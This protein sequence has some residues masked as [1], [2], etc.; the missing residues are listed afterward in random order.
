MANQGVKRS[1]P[2]M[3]ST[4][5]MFAFF[6]AAMI[7]APLASIL[8]MAFDANEPVWAQLAT[9]LPRILQ[10]TLLL[11]VAV[12]IGT[13][14]VGSA[15]AWLVTFYRF[16]GVGWLKWLLFA[17]LA[18][19]AY[20]AAYALVDFLEYAGPLQTSMRTAFGWS[21]AADYPFFDVR[22][23]GVAT[24]V[25]TLTLYPY[26]YLLT[27]AALREQSGAVFEVARSLGSSGVRAYLNVGLPLARPAIVAG[28]MIAMMET[29]ADFGTVEFF[30]V[31]TLTTGIFSLWLEAGN[32]G[33]AA[34]LAIIALFF[35]AIL[36]SVERFSRRR[37]KFYQSAQS[38]RPLVP[39]RLQGWRALTA[40][41]ICL[42]PVV[43]G[44]ALPVLIMAGHALEVSWADISL[45][46]AV[47][48]TIL[49]GLSAALV[50]TIVATL[51]VYSVR[52]AG[53]SGTRY[54][55]P[56]TSLGYA[57]PGAI[58]GLGVLIPLAAID[59]Q[60]ADMAERVTGS[61]PGLI[62][63]GSAFAIV[64]ACVVRFFAIPQG[65]A[66]AAFGRV[67][68]SLPLASRSLG[69]SA[70]GALRRVYL[71]MMRTSIATAL[72]LVFV[73]TVKELPATLMLRPFNFNTL[74]T[75]TYEKASLEN[76]AEAAPPAFLI[77]LVG[78]AAVAVVARTHR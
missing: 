76:I 11:M 68:P 12:G 8:V 75:R 15:T 57:T 25:L 5:S 54:L 14:I 47:G 33:G 70:G 29:L 17:P 18:I 39:E 27:R 63:T 10:N 58:L 49:V 38:T 53:G 26:T 44:F 37:M 61:D 7:L 50:A 28:S 66:D 56:A 71:P 40:L 67:S 73:D 74:A 35:V 31:Q 24:L 4:A 59:H 22:S 34:Q 65:A 51:L 48:N 30:A 78:L 52:L 43:L 3:P 69:Q 13:A 60:F 64:F 42:L 46:A 45:L 2:V 6:V 72:L 55:L 16:P 19:P 20:V 32:R 77:I 9:T 41:L 23:R 36:V 62:L 21:S 1:L